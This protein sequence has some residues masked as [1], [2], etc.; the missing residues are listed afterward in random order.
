VLDLIVGSKV[1]FTTI[2][3]RTF[4]VMIKPYTQSNT[5]L[6]LNG[7][8]LSNQFST[9]DQLLLIKPVIPA[10]IDDR[11]IEAILNYK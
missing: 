3:G 10:N 1:A 6:R 2:S 5:V 9:G 7:Q 11:I 4:E 8:G